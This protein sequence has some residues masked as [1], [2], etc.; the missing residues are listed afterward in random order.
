MENVKRMKQI[1]IA[2]FVGMSPLMISD[3]RLGRRFL[4]KTK[5]KDLSLKIQIPFETLA[6]STGESLYQRLAQAYMRSYL[7]QSEDEA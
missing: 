3:L 1:D 5:A 6:L 7:T 2:N 4:S